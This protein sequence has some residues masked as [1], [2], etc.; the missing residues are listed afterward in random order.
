MCSVPDSRLAASDCRPTTEDS[1]NKTVGRMMI[2]NPSS[3]NIVADSFARLP[4]FALNA[5]CS[6]Y[7]ATAMIRA[8]RTMPINGAIMVKQ[9]I[10][11]SVTAAICT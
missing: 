4:I 6:G 11:I 7:S 9:L 8:H 10:T 5:R 3:V 2:V 1:A